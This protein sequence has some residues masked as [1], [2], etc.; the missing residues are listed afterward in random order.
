MKKIAVNVFIYT[1]IACLVCF[2]IG[3]F[4]FKVPVLNANDIWA[5]RA[6]NGWLFVLEVLPSAVITGFL[7]GCAIYFGTIEVPHSRFSGML[8]EN[9]KPIIALCIIFTFAL[10]LS[11]DVLTPLLKQKKNAFEEKPVLITHYMNLAQDY[12][13]QSLKNHDYAA[14]AV[15]YSKKVIELDPKNEQAKELLKRAELVAAVKVNNQKDIKKV[16]SKSKSLVPVVTEPVDTVEIQKIKGSTTLELI[17][18]AEKYFEKKDYLAA[19]YYSQTAIRFAVE[20]DINLPKAKEIANKSWNILSQA[21]AETPTEENL[22]FLEKLRGYTKLDSGDFLSAYYIF[23]TLANE[24]AAYE[25]DPDVKRYLNAARDELTEQYFFTDEVT[26]K[27]AFESAQNVY[28]SLR[29]KD[30]TY[31]IFYIKGITD[32]EETGKYVRYLR[33]MSIYS[34]DALGNFTSV[35]ATPYAKMLAVETNTISEEKKFN[36]AIDDKWKVIPYVMLCSV[37]RNKEGVRTGP[38]YLDNKNEKFDGPNQVLLTMPYG[39]FDVLSQCANG[40]YNMNFWTMAKMKIDASLYGFSKEIILQTVL[41]SI[42]YPFM[43][44]IVLLFCASIGWNYRLLTENLFKFIW[45]FVIPLFHYILY[46][47]IGFFEF[48]IKLLNFIFVGIAGTTFALYLGIAFYALWI[49]AMSF[50]FLSRKGD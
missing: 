48:L 28:F 44:F 22:F 42:F 7:L 45:V 19:H 50:L 39:D 49:V 5:Y 1:F 26:D 6:N 12:Q 27:D 8:M 40:N 11:H 18:E 17:T 16:S 25:K 23:Q 4:A 34:F 9:F 10:S 15:Y 47:V 33:E 38:L 14:L 20:N 43:I 46:G 24:K 3:M 41:T 30:G 35:M 36:S 2:L 13:L 21:Q 37:D 32:I 31:D 29:H